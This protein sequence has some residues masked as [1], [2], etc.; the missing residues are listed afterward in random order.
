MLIRN[1]Q[2][3]DGTVSDV[4][5][6]RE[7]I[8]AIGRL[9]AMPSETM[10]D[11]QGS[12]LLPGLHDH[13]IHLAALAASLS[14]VRCG[15][16]EVNNLDELTACLRVP[17]QQW[18]RGIGYHESVAGMLDTSILDRIA[19]DRP[20]RIQH[21]SGRMWFF[22]SV[23]LEIILRHGVP[24]A[25]LE[26]V[27]GRY[28]GRL[29]DADAWLKQVLAS[30]PPD[31][32]QVG[33]LLS[34]M[35]VTGIT[36]MSPTNDAVMARH[37]IS[38]TTSYA[39]PQQVLLAGTLQLAH[40]ELCSRVTLGPAKLH[41]HESD[42][43]ELNDAAHFIS[44]AHQ[45]NRSVAIHCATEVELIYA[46]AALKQAG[47][48]SGDRIEHASV[49]PDF[50]IDEIAELGLAVVSQPHFVYERGEQYLQ[51]V[52]SESQPY[53][54][55]LRSF[56]DAGVCLAGGSDAPF[57]ECDPWASM[58]AAVTRSTKHGALIG[59]QEALTPEQALD[60]YLRDPQVLSQRRRVAVGASADLCLLDRVW[61][62]ARTSLAA[63]YVRATVVKGQVLYKR[64]E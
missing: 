10:L 34:R 18:L 39:L 16:P 13:H 27:D 59:A 53:L 41:L 19:T 6:E 47:I 1:A 43:P 61:S 54:Y 4:R 63:N 44:Q 26:C 14:S 2:L 35:G 21:R 7:T 36:D 48:K 11:A 52:D 64:A 32:T 50:A 55:R 22:N 45:Q 9:G 42:L 15:P 23:G 12:L 25:G 8:T 30:T 38:Q 24:P 5:I 49:T 62:D 46:L 40:V 37:F 3:E 60:L 58:K 20:V 56:L 28:T 31:F 57:G 17:G 33:K 51:D 29:F